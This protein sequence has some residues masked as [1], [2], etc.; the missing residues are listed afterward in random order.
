MY[1]AA[2][3]VASERELSG[4]IT[5]DSP[6]RALSLADRFGA[7]TRIIEVQATE[8]ELVERTLTHLRELARKVPR[9]GVEKRAEGETAARVK[10]TQAMVAHFRELDALAGIAR[11][12]RRKGKGKA[13]KFVST[14]AV[15]AFDRSLWLSGLSPGGR[16]AVSALIAAGTAEP[17]PSDVMKWL[18]VEG[19]RL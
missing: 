4:Y 16:R 6:R 12:V 3:R 14:G 8:E 5:T 13:A 10:C 2:V 17:G 11:G 18:L 15:Q 9:A 1:E 19:G 7:A